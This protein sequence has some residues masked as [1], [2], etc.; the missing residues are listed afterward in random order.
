M[1]KTLLM[2]CLTLYFGVISLN[3]YAEKPTSFG[4]VTKGK[5]LWDIA[6]ALRPDD[7]V[8][9]FQV[10]IALMKTNPDAFSN[11]CNYNTLKLNETLKLPPLDQIKAIP[12]Q[13]AN[14]EF[15]RQ[16]TQ[17]KNR[18]IDKNLTCGSLLEV[19]A[20]AP[21]EVK[22]PVAEPKPAP[23]AAT[24]P[25][26]EQHTPPTATT[27]PAMPTPPPA[28]LAPTIPPPAPQPVADVKPAEPAKSA[29]PAEFTKLMGVMLGLFGM[30]LLIVF[31]YD[32]FIDVD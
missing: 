28:Q 7:S 17:W 32:R 19:A 13:D 3:C 27:A 10:A 5:A 22:P 15:K 25:T 1:Q 4:P 24:P 31:I 2:L 23:T 16:G 8:D 29:L 30:M 12:A 18:K 20:V 21:A 9:P 14:T 26:H 6:I 11:R